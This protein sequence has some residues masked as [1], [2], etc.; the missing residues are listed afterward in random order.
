MRLW[1]CLCVRSLGVSEMGGEE[2][3]NGGKDNEGMKMRQTLMG[4]DFDV[5]VVVVVY[6]ELWGLR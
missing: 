1:L 4:S 6:N 2:W 5:F 3:V